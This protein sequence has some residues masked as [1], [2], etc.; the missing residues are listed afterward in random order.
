M[1]TV[2]VIYRAEP[3]GWWAESPDVSGYTAVGQSYDEVRELAHEGLPDFAGEELDF[4][5]TVFSLVSYAPPT[6][7]YSLGFSY[8]N[9]FVNPIPEEKMG[10]SATGVL[11]PQEA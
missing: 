10:S 8:T 9:Q 7:S 1:R 5:E 2:R 6:I 4:Q 3:E 11:S